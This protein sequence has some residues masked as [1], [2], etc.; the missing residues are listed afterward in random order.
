L[1]ILNSD[2]NVVVQTYN[3]PHISDSA[4]AREDLLG[5]GVLPKWARE[6]LARPQHFK[7]SDSKSGYSKKR[8]E[9]RVF[10]W[11]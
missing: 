3:H 9:R 7:T 6:F 4:G 1:L 5:D 10:L 11:A 2:G 8:K